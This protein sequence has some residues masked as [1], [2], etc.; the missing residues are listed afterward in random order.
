[1]HRSKRTLLVGTLLTALVILLP[2]AHLPTVGAINGIDG[3]AWPVLIPLG[4]ALVLFL[5]GDRVER[6]ATAITAIAILL[7]VAG[8]NFSTIKLLDA[9][10]AVSDTGGSVAIGAWALPLTS[11]VTLVGAFLGLSRR[12]G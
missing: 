7:T 6:P 4:S 1:V 3:D 10:R 12:V 8:L 2:C 9:H 5:I 11:G